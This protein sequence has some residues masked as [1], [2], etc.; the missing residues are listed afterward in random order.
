MD[1][2]TADIREVV[3]LEEWQ[4][5]RESFLGTW[6]HTPAENVEKLRAFLDG[7][8]D[9]RRLR[10]VH[11]YLTGTAFRIGMISHPD[12]DELLEEVREIRRSQ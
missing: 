5:L 2:N 6:K 9:P 12:I 4:E 1:W 10:I 8:D 3:E 7:F 11:N